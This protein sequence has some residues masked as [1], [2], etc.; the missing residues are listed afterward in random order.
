[1][2]FLLF[3]IYKLALHNVHVALY[4]PMRQSHLTFQVLIPVACFFLKG[5]GCRM[6]KIMRDQCKIFTRAASPWICNQVLYLLSYRAGISNWIG[7]SHCFSLNLPVKFAIEDQNTRFFSLFGENL[8]VPG[9]GHDIKCNGTGEIMMNQTG[10]QT[11]A[12]WILKYNRAVWSQET[13][14]KGKKTT[15]LPFFKL[16]NILVYGDELSIVLH[17]F[18]IVWVAPSLINQNILLL[19]NVD[20]TWLSDWATRT[21][22]EKWN[23][24][25]ASLILLNAEF[26]N[27]LW[28][29]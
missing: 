2:L 25:P 16:Q 17:F 3:V 6:G 4:I 12:P 11:K 15:C 23:V 27:Y 24:C 29:I 20:S 28:A 26:I 21:T 7:P 8:S 14:L 13:G 19:E 1:M 18:L 22:R 10:I 5:G 9:I